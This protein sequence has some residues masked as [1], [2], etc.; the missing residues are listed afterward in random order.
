MK[1]IS[2]LVLVLAALLLPSATIPG[3]QAGAQ[4]VAI[5]IHFSDT[6][7]QV[8]ADLYDKLGAWYDYYR[9]ANPVVVGSGDY[10]NTPDA[11]LFRGVRDG[12]IRAG[13]PW[14]SVI[15]APGNHDNPGGFGAVWDSVFGAGS[16]EGVKRVG[17]VLVGWMNTE[18]PNISAI[19]SRIL[20]ERQACPGC[21]GVLV[22]HKPVALEP[23]LPSYLYT[24][25]Y[26]F[27]S[28]ARVMDLAQQGNFPLYLAGHIEIYNYAQYGTVWQNRPGGARN[29]LGCAGPRRVRRRAGWPPRR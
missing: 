23:G 11:T 9:W 22:G 4:G 28:S 25:T 6:S 10:C 16:R 19:S 26:I 24:T 20:A 21:V 12:L 1:R 2:V 13:I 18:L 8:P 27:A 3:A 7:A 29:W 15:L 17:N 5:I 14:E